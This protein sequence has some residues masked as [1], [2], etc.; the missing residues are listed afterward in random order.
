[1]DTQR[2]LL[3]LIA[4]CVPPIT[5]DEFCWRLSMAMG[6]RKARCQATQTYLRN[7]VGLK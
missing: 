4:Q 5:P 7:A 3:M 1:M 2:P 6:P